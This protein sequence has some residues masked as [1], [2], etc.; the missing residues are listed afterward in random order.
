MHQSGMRTVAVVVDWARAVQ[1]RRGRRGRIVVVNMVPRSL[2]SLFELV[3]MRVVWCS[4]RGGSMGGSL[5]F[6][7]LGGFV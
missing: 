4:G 7:W 3:K 6:W 1:A 5:A 2:S